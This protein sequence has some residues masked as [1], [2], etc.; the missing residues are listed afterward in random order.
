LLAQLLAQLLAFLRRQLAPGVL[1]WCRLTLGL[2]GTAQLG[3]ALIT[4]RL[5]VAR[6]RALGAGL[7][8]GA[9]GDEE[10]ANQPKNCFHGHNMDAVHV[11]RVPI[12]PGLLAGRQKI[13]NSM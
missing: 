4:Q 3:A 1:C 7:R 12:V 6:A 2:Q 11:R 5:L 13:C 8:P 9:P 10:N